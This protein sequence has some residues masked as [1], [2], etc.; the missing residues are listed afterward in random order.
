[1]EDISRSLMFWENFSGFE[2]REGL[3]IWFRSSRYIWMP[4]ILRI[5]F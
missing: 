2:A 5:G 4:I 1:M 3:I